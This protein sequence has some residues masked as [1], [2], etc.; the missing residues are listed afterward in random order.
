MQHDCEME[1]FMLRSL[2]IRCEVLCHPTGSRRMTGN[3][4]EVFF[5]YS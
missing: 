4:L 1:C 5:W 3:F 2:N